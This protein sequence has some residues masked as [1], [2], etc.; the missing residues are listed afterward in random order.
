MRL[1]SI[2]K[3]KILCCFVG[4]GSTDYQTQV[5]VTLLTV[6]DPP[7]DVQ[8]MQHQVKAAV[9][10]VAVLNI[11]IVFD[12]ADDSTIVMKEK[13][14]GGFFDGQSPVHDVFQMS[15]NGSPFPRNLSELF[16]NGCISS[17]QLKKPCCMFG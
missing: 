14:R 13:K 12:S 17:F 5:L 9:K 1:M 2:N 8:F 7:E 4:N 15:W 6:C 11:L 10:L 3:R 16:R